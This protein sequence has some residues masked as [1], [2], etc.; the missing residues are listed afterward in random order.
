MDHGLDS[1]C[2]DRFDKVFSGHFHTRSDNGKIFYLGNPY[3]MFW[4]DVLDNRGFT[5]FDTATLEHY[6]INNPLR[7]FYN[8]YY[9]DTDY[10]MFDGRIRKQNPKLIVRKKSDIVQFEKF[11]DKL[12]I[13]WLD[14][15]VVENFEFNGWYGGE[16]ETIESEDTL[17]SLIDILMNPKQNLTNGEFKTSQERFIKSMWIDLRCISLLLKERKRRERIL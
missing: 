10:R 8:I 17:Q 12:Y 14:L 15:K 6:P 7:L 2:F 16:D 3:E 9:E 1:D 4:T 11:V 5:I 13:W